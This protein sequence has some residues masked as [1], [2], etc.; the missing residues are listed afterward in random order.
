M[1]NAKQVSASGAVMKGLEMPL[2][3]DSNRSVAPEQLAQKLHPIYAMNANVPTPVS[4]KMDEDSGSL[5]TVVSPA[6]RG[7]FFDDAG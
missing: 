1:A 2:P 4:R 5:S 3:L 6:V 7:M